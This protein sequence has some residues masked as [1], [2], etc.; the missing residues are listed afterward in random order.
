MLNLINYLK[1]LFM[2]EETLQ[3]GQ[4]DTVTGVGTVTAD[5]G[6]QQTVTGDATTPV[7]DPT[8]PPVDPTVAPVDPA[9]APV[10]PVVAPAVDPVVEPP[11]SV[12]PTPIAPAEP[13]VIV[14]NGQVVSKRLGLYDADGAQECELADGTTAFVPKSVLGE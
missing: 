1:G 14:Y 10:D 6:M 9:V 11:V 7:V 12:E 3:A 4:T 13:V 2:S 5:D 8:V